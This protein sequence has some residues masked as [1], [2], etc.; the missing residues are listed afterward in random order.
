MSVPAR[1]CLRVARVSEEGTVSAA[2]ELTRD[3]GA[4]RASEA[5]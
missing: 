1:S 5:A 4:E 3:D 2:N